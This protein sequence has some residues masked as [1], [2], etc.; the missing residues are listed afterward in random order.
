MMLFLRFNNTYTS[1]LKVFPSI[2]L[3]EMIGTFILVLIKN[4]HN[5]FDHMTGETDLLV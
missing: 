1:F 4:Q 5:Y 2:A 3:K